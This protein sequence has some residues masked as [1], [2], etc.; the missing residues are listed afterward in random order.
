MGELIVSQE[1]QGTPTK[2]IPATPTTVW[3]WREIFQNEIVFDFDARKLWEDPISDFVKDRDK[4]TYEWFTGCYIAEKLHQRIK[5]IPHLFAY[6]GG[7]GIHIHIFFSTEQLPKVA[8][9]ILR[10]SLAKI[11][12][13]V[14]LDDIPKSIIDR[15]ADLTI[16]KAT[17][18]LIRDF[19]SGKQPGFYKTLIGK[20]PANLNLL[21]NQL[22]LPSQIELWKPALDIKIMNDLVNI[23]V[24]ITKEHKVKSAPK[25]IP[26]EAKVYPRIDIPVSQFPPCYSLL[27]SKIEEAREKKTKI[28]FPHNVRFALVTFLHRL[29]WENNEIIKLFEV[30][31]D[32]DYNMTAYQ[33]SQI[34]IRDYSSPKCAT[35]KMQGFCPFGYTSSCILK[36][37][38]IATHPFDVVFDNITKK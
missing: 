13:D 23:P 9:N 21:K 26:I 33:V 20:C 25:P 37:Q 10:Y 2:Y 38:K 18:H 32:F 34:V 14:Y 6:S 35:I 29:G 5:N 4:D 30:M 36:N 24:S 15:I 19:G 22:I 17:R 1:I 27:L 16:I 8:P 3:A 11:I 7:K 12:L 28:S 31:Q